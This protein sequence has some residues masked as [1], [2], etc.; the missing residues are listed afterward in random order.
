MRGWQ[1]QER[2]ISSVNLTNDVNGKIQ[3]QQAMP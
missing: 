2:E 1:E 3:Q